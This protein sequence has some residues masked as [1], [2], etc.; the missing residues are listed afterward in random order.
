MR[1][2]SLSVGIW[3][4][5]DDD[6][7]KQQWPLS[8]YYVRREALAALMCVFSVKPHKIP[9]REV[10]AYR[11]FIFRMSKVDRE[12][13]NNLCRSRTESWQSRYRNPCCLTPEPVWLPCC[14]V[15]WLSKVGL[16][17]NRWRCGEF[18]EI[19]HVSG[20]DRVK[21]AGIAFSTWTAKNDQGKY[22]KQQFSDVRPV[23][24]AQN[25]NLS[26]EGNKWDRSSSLPGVHTVFSDTE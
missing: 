23:E 16:G 9:M 6:N 5:H 21:G 1:W 13:L 12:R 7:F 14:I 22:A 10:C 20:D 15:N 17:E 26:E 8:N 3:E 25:S 2:W 24:G 18:L 19:R 4:D 11:L